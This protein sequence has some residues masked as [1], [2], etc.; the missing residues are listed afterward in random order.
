MSNTD[1]QQF[2]LTSATG[3][4]IAHGSMSSVMEHLPDTHARDA[5]LSSM[6]RTAT[7]AVEAEQRRAEAYASA[8]Q[9][10]SDTVEHLTNRMD[11]YIAGREDQRRR[12]AE[13]AE[14]EEQEEIQ[15]TLDA[16][17]DPDDD[18]IPFHTPTGDLHALPAPEDPEGS[19]LEGDDQG[20]TA[21]TATRPVADPA[22]LGGVPDPKQGATQP[23]AISLNEE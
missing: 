2:V 20:L 21:V 9:M 1:T 8:A 19:D 4:V 15:R 13:E 3:E 11:A 22:E 17:P 5:A 6:L 7:D 23:I 12:D 18:P 16:L 10:I 14:R